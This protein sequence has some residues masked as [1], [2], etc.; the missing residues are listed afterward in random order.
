MT[1][2]ASIIERAGSDIR[3]TWSVLRGTTRESTG[4][5]GGENWAA[6]IAPLRTGRTG[7]RDGVG[8]EEDDVVGDAAARGEECL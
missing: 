2:L 4:R 3:A 8:A 6:T 7:A 1:R 5:L